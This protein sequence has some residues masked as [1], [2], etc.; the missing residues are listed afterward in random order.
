[1]AY[2][3]HPLYGGV[4]FDYT[5]QQ[6]LDPVELQYLRE[7]AALQQS[8]YLQQHLLQQQQQEEGVYMEQSN[9]QVAQ[10]YSQSFWQQQMAPGNFKQGEQRLSEA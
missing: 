7:Q 2:H 10:S 6:E 4:S 1:M 3:Q 8:M 5:N 9:Y